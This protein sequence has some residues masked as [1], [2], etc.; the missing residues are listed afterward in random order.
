MG[1]KIGLDID[2]VVADSFP[3]F[4]TELNKHYGKNITELYDYNMAEVYDVAWDDMD[5]F[6]NEN[7]EYLFSVPQPMAGALETIRS[8][9]NDGHEVFFITA[10]RRGAEERVT[11]EWLKQH[12]FPL[13]KTIFVGAASKTFA[14]REFG[15]DVFVEDF[16][17]NALEIA[18]TGIPVLLLDASYNRG[19]TP[20]GVTRCRDWEEIKRYIQTL[21]GDLSSRKFT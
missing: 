20:Q 12:S 15:I 8:F 18:A 7:M 11:M 14:V 6:F 5:N 4:I 9:L 19:K 13:D 17:G 10:R 2:G 21:E 1:L 3:V 16:M